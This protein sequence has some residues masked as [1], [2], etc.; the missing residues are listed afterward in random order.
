MFSAD[1]NVIL[2]LSKWTLNAERLLD[3]AA[4]KR[5]YAV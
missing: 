4:V 5:N 3:S 1:L 2:K